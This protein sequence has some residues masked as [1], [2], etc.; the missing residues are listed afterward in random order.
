M[1]VVVR[2]HAKLAYAFMRVIDPREMEKLSRTC[3]KLRE[4]DPVK[5]IREIM[6]DD[7]E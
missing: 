2:K 6:M 7:G 4:G 5:L 3:R 1:A